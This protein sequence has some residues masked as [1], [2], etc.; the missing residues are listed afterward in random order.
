MILEDITAILGPVDDDL[1][2]QIYQTGAS[3]GE[4]SEAWAWLNADEALANQGRSP[5][6]G[7]VAELIAL[8]EAAELDDD[9]PL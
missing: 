8:I 1:V 3:H 9:A 6:S 4:L 2:A 7:K 5:P